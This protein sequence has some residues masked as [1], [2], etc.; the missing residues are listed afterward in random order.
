MI[1]I[2]QQ[3]GGVN[4]IS[5]RIKYL[6]YYIPSKENFYYSLLYHAVF[7]KRKISSD[8]MEILSSI[9][10]E[11][12]GFNHFIG[13]QYKVYLKN[14]LNE[15]NYLVECPIDYSVYFNYNKEYNYN[16]LSFKNLSKIYKQN[17]YN[18]ASK[19]KNKYFKIY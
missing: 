10:Q 1:N 8:Y 18:I 4:I 5:T 3:I 9:S 11:L 2:Y 12:Y 17:F 14:F 19:L 7:H 6:N 16:K 15:N 13:N